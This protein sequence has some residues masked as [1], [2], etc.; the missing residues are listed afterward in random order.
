M[1]PTRSIIPFVKKWNA[2]FHYVEESWEDDTFNDEE[3]ERLLISGQKP[4][5]CI[6]TVMNYLVD[7]SCLVLDLHSRATEV[8]VSGLSPMIVACNEGNDYAQ[9]LEITD[10]EIFSKSQPVES[11][12]LNSTLISPL[13]DIL[14]TEDF[15]CFL[16]I[17]NYLK[18]YIDN[19]MN[20][21]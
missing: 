4:S 5:C 15:S 9:R 13:L 19:I 7:A 11:V 3:E 18:G 12:D 2:V 17:T 20:S 16:Y 1:D 6:S 21:K 10:A 14:D 8:P